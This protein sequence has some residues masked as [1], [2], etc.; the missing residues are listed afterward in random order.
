MVLIL[1]LFLCS[2]LH[3]NQDR[4]IHLSELGKFGQAIIDSGLYHNLTSEHFP[5]ELT[6]SIDDYLALLGTFSPCMP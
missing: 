4:E 5:Y 1:N 2:T 6:Y 3:Q